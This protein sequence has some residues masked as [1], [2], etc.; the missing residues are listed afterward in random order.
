M[1]FPKFLG[2]QEASYLWLCAGPEGQ[3]LQPLPCP[4]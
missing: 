2:E 3:S 1:N 4:L